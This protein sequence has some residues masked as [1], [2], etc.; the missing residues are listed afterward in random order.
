M[1]KEKGATKAKL[2]T[3]TI[4]VF[5]SAAAAYAEDWSTNLSSFHGGSYDGW[6]R[7]TMTNALGV[8]AVDVTL[9]S[10]VD[11]QFVWT[12]ANPALA[13][14]TITATAPGGTITN[15]GTIRVSVRGCR[16][17]AASVVIYSGNAT[18]KV[19]AATFSGDGRTLQI[20]VTAAFTNADTLTA[21]GLKLADMRLAPAG[22]Q[23]LA[24]DFTGDG[25]WD[26]YDQYALL[27]SVAWLGGAY[28]GWDLH[29]SA[30]YASLVGA[31]G[32]VVMIR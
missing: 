22:T 25:V 2:A 10:G 19:S 27:V 1:Q 23:R 29:A 17:D 31:R 20:P 5:L 15:G 26:V 14:L 28:D 30:D 12:Q 18:G 24:L 4:G 7:Q 8:S 6:D 3:M 32:T 11:Q 9:S 16:F 21:S 13:L